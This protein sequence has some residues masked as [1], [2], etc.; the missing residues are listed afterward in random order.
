MVFDNPEESN[1][2]ELILEYSS[3]T[4]LKTCTTN[5][6]MLILL[7]DCIYYMLPDLF[8]RYSLDN[9]LFDLFQLYGRH[10]DF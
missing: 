10:S 7:V 6:I 5:V 4:A 3:Y 2:Y 1:I 9:F 8:V